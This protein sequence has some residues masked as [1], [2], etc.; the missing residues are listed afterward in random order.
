MAEP[1]HRVLWARNAGLAEACLRSP[2]V[3]GLG[4]G[5]LDQEEFRRYVA[6][7]A[8]FLRAFFSAYALVAARTADRMKVANNL[9]FLMAGVLKELELHRHYAEMLRIDLE[10][11]TPNAAAKDYTDFLAETAWNADAGETLAAMTPCMRLYAW[12]GQQLRATD[13]GESPYTEW[14]DTYG[15]PEF[16][17]LARDLEVLLDDLAADMPERA[18][19][20]YAEAMRYELAFFEAFG[21]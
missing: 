5:S 9:V 1:L 6:Q 18:A 13:Y 14:I 11:V 7:D 17:R 15:A 8:F 12:L 20:V 19:E 16:E 21:G 2:F 4:D 3:R 10:S